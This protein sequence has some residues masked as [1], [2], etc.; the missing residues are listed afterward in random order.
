[1][2]DVRAIRGGATE[3]EAAVIAVVLDRIAEEERSAADRQAA[4]SS[5]LPAWVRAVRPDQS[6]HP[7]D[8]VAPGSIQHH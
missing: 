4:T 5:A 6:I 2:P 8:S 7:M 3:F 1:M